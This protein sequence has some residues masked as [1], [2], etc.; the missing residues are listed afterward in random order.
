MPIF[1]D[2]DFGQLRRY[3]AEQEAAIEA[4]L[5]VSGLADLREATA[6]AEEAMQSWQ[7]SEPRIWGSA[8]RGVYRLLNWKAGIGHLLFALDGAD[9]AAERLLHRGIARWEAAGGLL[10][11]EAAELRQKLSKR[12]AR[13]VIHHMGAHLV[14]SVAIAVPIP[15]VRSLARFL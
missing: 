8:I 3:I 14:L 10:P 5:G 4:S 1:D 9:R 15:G 12:E 2:I 11:A 13:S 7:R 6:N